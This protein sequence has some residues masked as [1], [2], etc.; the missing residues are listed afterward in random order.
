MS[1]HMNKVY[2]FSLSYDQIGYLKGRNVH[3]EKLKSRHIPLVVWHWT[4]SFP[5]CHWLDTAEG[6]NYGEYGL[7]FGL[8][9]LNLSRHLDYLVTLI[10]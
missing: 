4:T 8:N 3:E 10:I 6:E 2:Y 1:T 9:H 5:G 7:D